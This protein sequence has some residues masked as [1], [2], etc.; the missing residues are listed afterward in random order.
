M[1]QPIVVT[2]PHRLGKEE[3]LRRLQAGFAKMVG[4]IGAVASIGR[5]EWTGDHLDFSIGVLGQTATGGV[6][7]GEDEVR[8]EILLPGM[9]GMLADKVRD[10]IAKGG[11]VLLEKK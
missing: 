5:Q 9:L 1:S 11:Q 10:M 3:A 6:D 7:V 2:I 8:L 4:T